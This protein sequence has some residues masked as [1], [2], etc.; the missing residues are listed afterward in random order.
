MLSVSFR[1]DA[2][3]GMEARGEV[4]VSD[5]AIVRAKPTTESSRLAVLRK[6]ANVEVRKIFFTHDTKRSSTYKWY[7]VKSPAGMGYI[8]SDLIK[9]KKQ[10]NATGT[11]TEDIVYRKGAGEQMKQA[12][13]IKA[14]KTFTVK[15]EAKHY[16]SS[17]MWYRIKKGDKYYYVL[18]EH[19][20]LSDVTTGLPSGFKV[21]TDDIVQ[22]KAALKVI[23][24]ACTWA[25]TIAADN[26]FHYGK[27][28]NSQHNGCYFCGTNTKRGGRSKKG[29]KDYKFS[30]CCNPF[31]HAAYSHGGNELTMLEICKKGK[32]YWVTDYPKSALF[33]N[34]VKPDMS[35]LKKGDVLCCSNHV[36]LYVGNGEVAEAA[37]GDDNV[38]NSSKWN[39]SI[40]VRKLTKS[41]YKK[42]KVYRYI[43][44][45][46]KY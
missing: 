10:G 26:R 42:Y 5:G 16:G 14:G 1:S 18:A 34:L 8:R 46:K 25:R 24:G 13:T 11:A 21:D 22:S 38:R 2:L 12:G 7:Y 41:R 19:V 3:T 4:K 32:S 43:S 30:Y 45:G 17:A 33:A 9:I 15:M 39:S 36:M 27:K 37:G 6:G 31:V 28:P 40:A 20:E 29:V 44:D 23:N 35:K